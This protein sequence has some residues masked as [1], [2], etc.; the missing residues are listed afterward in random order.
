MSCL[1]VNVSVKPIALKPSVSLYCSVGSVYLPLFVEDGYLF[2]E[3][4]G[5]TYFLCVDKERKG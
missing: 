1:Q 2:V 5:V 4:N 3:E